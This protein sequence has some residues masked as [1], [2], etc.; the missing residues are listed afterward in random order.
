MKAHVTPPAASEAEQDA[1]VEAAYNV[2]AILAL[3]AHA[4]D[5]INSADVDQKNAQRLAGDI[6]RA[7]E[8]LEEMVGGI[9]GY[10]ERP[11]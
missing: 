10:L 2:S 9:I 4:A 7:S 3:I 8:F 6:R 11:S 1:K 5:F